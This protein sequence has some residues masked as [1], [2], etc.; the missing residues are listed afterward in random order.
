MIVNVDTLLSRSKERVV[1]SS[2]NQGRLPGLDGL[3]AVSIAGVLAVHCSETSG[4][5]SLGPLDFFIRNGGFGVDI[6]F[7]L[8]GFLITSLL[9]KEENRFGS[10]SISAFYLRRCIR[11]LP[12]ALAYLTAMLLAGFIG[13]TGVTFTEWAEAAGFLRNYVGKAWETGHY[14]S[15]AVEEQ[16]YFAWPLLLLILPRRFR[17]PFGI[18]G[19]LIAPFWRYANLRFGMVANPFRFDMH[20]DALLVGCLLAFLRFDAKW[21]NL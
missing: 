15:L 12:P 5:P 17:I 11:I 21:L 10:F 6:F 18:A 4:F 8:S 13:L 7:V 1:N 2:T 16:F 3:R 9:L 14:W 20:C 19:V